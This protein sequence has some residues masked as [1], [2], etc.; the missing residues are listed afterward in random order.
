MKTW[1]PS[2]GEKDSAEG[3]VST[4]YRL[5]VS[6]ILATLILGGLGASFG[7]TIVEMPAWRHVGVAA[8]AAFS[9]A[10]DLGNGK[11]VYAVEGI[12]SALLTLAAAI[13]FRLS[14][15][16]PRSIAIPVYGA[17]LMKIGVLLVTTQAAPIMLSV[18]GL[19]DDP[20]A[21]QRA[22]DAFDRWGNL[23]AVF[24]ALGY[25]ATL[26][27]LVAIVRISSGSGKGFLRG[28]EQTKSPRSGYTQT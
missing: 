21:L 12:G 20:V 1:L 26:W 14:R 22:F 3:A 19:G 18:P 6:F 15:T 23:R 9:R 24:V 27:A 4:S 2:S 13:C 17:V 25:F 10:A 5:T 16:R 28:A 7:R 8:W 11:I